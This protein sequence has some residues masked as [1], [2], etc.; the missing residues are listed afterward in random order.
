MKKLLCVFLMLV[1]LLSFASCGS[2]DGVEGTWYLIDSETD[3]KFS[4]G[5]IKASNVT[6]G[7][8]EVSDNLVHVVMENAGFDHELYFTQLDGTDVLVTSLSGDGHVV[9]CK[10]IEKTATISEKFEVENDKINAINAFASYINYDLL[11]VWESEGPVQSSRTIEFAADG[12]VITTDTDGTVRRFQAV[13]D[14]AGYVATEV[15]IEE[16]SEGNY[17]PTFT[18][19]VSEEGSSEEPGSLTVAK[20][21]STY[22]ENIVKINDELYKKIIIEEEQDPDNDVEDSEEDY[23]IETPE[24][25]AKLSDITVRFEADRIEGSRLLGTVFTENNSEETFEGNV[26]VYFYGADGKKLGNDTIIVDELLPGRE[27]WA[28]VSIDAYNGTPEMD[29][30]FTEVS[31]T[32]LEKTTAEVDE[33]ATNNTKDLFYWSFDGVSWYNDVTDITVY[34]DGTCVVTVKNKTKEDGQFY[35]AAVWSCGEDYGVDTVQV[36]DSDGTIKSV[37]P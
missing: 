15:G 16:D 4:S 21:D 7:T 17:Y 2:N 22:G 19:F 6:V 26:H 14:D 12:V 23:E 11:G 37:Y 1:M 25:N 36:V 27:S 28:N 34:T 9:L 29:V 24:S 18:M 30:E 35:A 33:E 32:P 5:K 13:Y 10:D 20:T 31:F 3:F 8:Y